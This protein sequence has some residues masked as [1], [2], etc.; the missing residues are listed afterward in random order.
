MTHFRHF[1]EILPLTRWEDIVAN[2]GLVRTKSILIENA[3]LLD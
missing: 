1:A 2:V 3:V